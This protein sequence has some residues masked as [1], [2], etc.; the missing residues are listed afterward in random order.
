MRKIIQFST[1][2]ALSANIALFV[3]K[4]IGGLASHSIA[5][6]SD[7]INS[8]TDIIASIAIVIAVRFSHKKADHTHPFGHKR[9]EPIAGMIVAIIAALLGFEII[10]ESITMFLQKEVIILTPFTYSVVIFTIVLKLGM[11]IFFRYIS[12][13]HRT[14]AIKALAADSINDV[15]VSL[16]V[17]LSFAMY[18][19]KIPYVD[20]IAGVFIGLWI[21]RT[22][23]MVG[24]ENIDYLMGRQPS[25]DVMTK[26]KS[27][28]TSI[29]GVKAIN[30]VFA[31]YVGPYVHAEVHIELNKSLTVIQAHDIGKQVQH[32]IEN[33]EIVD[34][35]FIHIDPHGRTKQMLKKTKK[36]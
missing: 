20:G 9:A 8:L 28:A 18:H 26:I 25:D 11:F 1:Y 19:F 4:L 16:V 33:V 6:I 22:G 21:I 32:K 27:C 10:K 12:T 36:K 23:F 7:A 17:L 29:K 2:L 14:P 3:L 13:K 35:A 15:W 31:H 34:R 24:K 5:L 30:D